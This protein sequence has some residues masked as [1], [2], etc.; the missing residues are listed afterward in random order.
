[1]KQ[2]QSI[3][4][5]TETHTKL[6][7][8]KTVTINNREYRHRTV[9]YVPN[10]V[11]VPVFSNIDCHCFLSAQC[12]LCLC[13]L[14]YWLSLFPVCPMLS[15]SVL[16]FIYCHCVLCIQFCLCLCIVFYWLSLFPVCP[17]LSVSLYSL[18]L[19]FTV[20][21]VLNVV[22]VSVLSLIDC[23]C[24]LCAQCCLV[25]INNRQYRDT[26]NIGLTGNSDNQ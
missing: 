2:W 7:T 20:S 6:D 15:V 16:S 8:Q 26:Q 1:M 12:C 21:C 22:C 9:S 3:I 5:N 24:F 18:L 13:I 19:I 11:Y 4:D 10:V 17:M 25:I 14:Y 23:H